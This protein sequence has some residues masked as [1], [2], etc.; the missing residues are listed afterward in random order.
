M[1]S[2]AETTK[3]SK[4]IETL[5]EMETSI[6]IQT[7]Q[8]AKKV[9]DHTGQAVSNGV[10]NANKSTEILSNHIVNFDS[11]MI[12]SVTEFRTLVNS[13]IKGSATALRNLV[14][15]RDEE[16]QERI[17]NLG[18]EFVKAVTKLDSQIETHREA[19]EKRQKIL[20]QYIATEVTKTSG[21]ILELIKHQRA[22]DSLESNKRLKLIEE[23]TKT[24]QTQQVILD[25]LTEN[26]SK[27]KSIGSDTP[28]S[29]I[30][31]D[32]K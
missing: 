18:D 3:T 31:E 16:Q 6:N 23:I 24:L 19:E 13:Q 1:F 15:L 12:A 30:Q 25:T 8:S 7:A 17:K 27:V 4:L 22:Y 14:N 21:T 32:K 28:Q 29:E 5:T 11:N 9:N 26:L 20:Q 2:V 10:I